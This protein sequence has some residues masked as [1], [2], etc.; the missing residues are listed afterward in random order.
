MAISRKEEAR[1][2]SAEERVLVDKSHHPELQDLNDAELANLVK[3]LRG[4][5]DKRRR[6][7]VAAKC[8]AKRR[9]KVQLRR[10]KTT[11]LN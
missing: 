10:P 11:A 9:R 1:A 3:L 2:L 7:A 4:Q 6:I 8:V 5:R